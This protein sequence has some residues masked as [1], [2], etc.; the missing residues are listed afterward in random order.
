MET[1]EDAEMD[2][3]R[4]SLSEADVEVVCVNERETLTVRDPRLF[5]AVVDLLDVCG[6]EALVVVVPVPVSVI[7]CDV[8]A[9]LVISCVCANVH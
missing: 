9:L 4:D 2:G 7:E 1:D 3:V 6:P 5:D 8:E